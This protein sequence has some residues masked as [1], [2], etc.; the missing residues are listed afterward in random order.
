M[1]AK[2][3]EMPV[4]PYREGGYVLRVAEIR[5]RRSGQV[6]QVPI[7]VVQMHGTRY[8]V[9][10]NRGRPWVLN[11]LVDNTCTIAA[12]HEREHYRAV[13]VTSDEAIPVLRT[14]LTQLTFAVQEFP[15]SVTASD[16]Q[17]RAEMEKVAVFRLEPA[18]T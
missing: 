4:Q 10:P 13:L 7:A 6:H 9:S 5:G 18:P 1:V 8:L 11:L 16:A 3:M 14:Y 17:I 2:I 12:G 15:F